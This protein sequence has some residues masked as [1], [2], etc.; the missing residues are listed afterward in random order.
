MQKQNKSYRMMCRCL[1]G[2]NSQSFNFK[3][4]LILWG[5]NSPRGR[6]RPR[7]CR[8]T[9]STQVDFELSIIVVIWISIHI[10][11]RVSGACSRSWAITTIRLPQL[12]LPTTLVFLL[13]LDTRPLPPSTSSFSKA[14]L[15]QASPVCF[16]SFCAVA[17]G[18][19]EEL[20]QRR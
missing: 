16:P 5:F 19:Q 14:Q 10:H 18:Q 20:L 15:Q 12:R 4:S 2:Y 3:K 6:S 11:P 9:D 1:E 8:D 13:L 7:R 17:R